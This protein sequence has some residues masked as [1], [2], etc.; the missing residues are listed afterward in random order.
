MP[1]SSSP[2]F[3]CSHHS[4]EELNRPNGFFDPSGWK[5]SSFVLSQ[6]PAP[7]GI[8][9]SGLEAHTDCSDSG[10]FRLIPPCR[11]PYQGVLEN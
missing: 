9:I 10:P 3:I 4:I 1:K 11:S 5:Y 8:N 6:L 7:S 2:C